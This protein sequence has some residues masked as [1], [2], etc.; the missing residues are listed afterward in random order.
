MQIL[1]NKLSDV[2]M[3]KSESEF[4][5]LTEWRGHLYLSFILKPGSGKTASLQSTRFFPVLY[6]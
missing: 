3:T 2:C 4:T 1:F 5:K 6:T